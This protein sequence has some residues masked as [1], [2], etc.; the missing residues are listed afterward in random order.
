MEE[1]AIASTHISLLMHFIERIY[2][3]VYIIKVL[4]LTRKSQSHLHAEIAH[5]SIA[6]MSLRAFICVRV[7]LRVLFAIDRVGVHPHVRIYG[8][9][10]YL[11]AY[12]YIYIYIWYGSQKS[13]R[14]L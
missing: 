4:D 10:K 2:M 7:R 6:T 11:W 12:I 9:G 3:H 14:S 8:G 13:P 5:A 1:I